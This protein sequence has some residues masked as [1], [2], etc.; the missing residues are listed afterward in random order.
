MSVVTSPKTTTLRQ[1]ISF[2]ILHQVNRRTMRTIQH[3]DTTALFGMVLIHQNNELSQS[4]LHV[5]Q[6]I[7][8]NKQTLKCHK[9]RGVTF[10]EYLVVLGVINM[11]DPPIIG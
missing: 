9:T 8:D 4:V 10:A 2:R 5:V 3:C 7:F 11:E 6:Y 1:N